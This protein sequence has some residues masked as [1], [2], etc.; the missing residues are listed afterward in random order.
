M[1]KVR[2]GV[3]S[4]KAADLV[5]RSLRCFSGPI[6]VWH[7]EIYIDDDNEVCVLVSAS[8]GH[9]EQE[10]KDEIIQSLRSYSSRDNYICT[11]LEEKRN[12]EKLADVLEGKPTADDEAIRGRKLNPIEAFSVQIMLAELKKLSRGAYKYARM[13]LGALNSPEEDER[14]VSLWEKINSIRNGRR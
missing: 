9:S 3:Y 7:D 12:A 11:S 4:M 2:L 10:C 13:G 5:G 1:L 8:D 14:V 6:I